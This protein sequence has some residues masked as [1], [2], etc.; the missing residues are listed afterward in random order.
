MYRTI[1]QWPYPSITLTQLEPLHFLRPFRSRPAATT[2]LE[3]NPLKRP[4]RNSDGKTLLIRRPAEMRAPLAAAVVPQAV[5]KN[6]DVT[7]WTL[8]SDTLIKSLEEL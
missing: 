5:T 2:I 8:M 3:R 7:V 1:S 4:Q 6:E